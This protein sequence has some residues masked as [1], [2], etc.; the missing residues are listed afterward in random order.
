MC[1]TPRTSTSRRTT[2]LVA[3]A[4]GA[5]AGPATATGPAEWAE[6]QRTVAAAC[7]AA[8][9]FVQPMA[10]GTPVEFDDR[11]GITALFIEGRYPQPHM[12]PR[13][14]RVLCLFDRR[15]GLAHVAPA[16]PA[17]PQRPR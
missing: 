8:S 12:Q 15:S 17:P 6:H 13:K 10:A 16:D 2:L 9:G 5:A 3:L 1:P 7:A 4:V 11:L 14:G